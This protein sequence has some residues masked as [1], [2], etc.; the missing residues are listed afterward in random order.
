[1]SILTKAGLVKRQKG[2]YFLTA[3]GKVIYS[4][5]LN[6]EAKVESAIDNYWKLKAVDLLGLL[7]EKTQRDNH[8]I[9]R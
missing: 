3:F 4:A 6:L 9:N 7:R 8:C 5:H 1:M 2:R